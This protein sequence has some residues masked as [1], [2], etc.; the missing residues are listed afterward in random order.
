ML[1]VKGYKQ[2]P[3][4]CG[5]ACLKMVLG[6]WGVK[7]SMN[8]LG[9][10]A[11]TTTSRGT[12]A[13]CMVRAA[14]HFGFTGFVMSNVPFAHLRRY[15]EKKIPVIINWFYETEGHYSVVVGIDKDTIYLRDPS[16]GRMRSLPL[17][18]F[19][20]IWFDFSLPLSRK[21]KLFVRRIVVITPT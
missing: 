8:R 18:V 9:T 4:F 10:L 12:R 21:S 13:E 19:A 6:Y 20:G 17:S 16:D 15:L 2:K 14:R 11:R 3:S 5:P 1:R 7:A